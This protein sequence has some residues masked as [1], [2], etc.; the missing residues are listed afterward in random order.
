[1]N[2]KIGKQW[3]NPTDEFIRFLNKEFVV[4]DYFGPEYLLWETLKGIEFYAQHLQNGEFI[5]LT[6]YIG[7]L[8]YVK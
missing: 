1:M 2:C 6:T 3:F 8:K 7:M 4:R 5:K